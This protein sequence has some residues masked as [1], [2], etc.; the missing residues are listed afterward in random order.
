MQAASLKNFG[1]AQDK[2]YRVQ[3]FQTCSNNT[4]Y[5]SSHHQK[6]KQPKRK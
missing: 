1:E 2:I 4:P 5:R 3:P 6:R